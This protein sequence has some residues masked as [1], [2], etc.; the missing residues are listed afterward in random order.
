MLWEQLLNS[1]HRDWRGDGRADDRLDDPAWVRKWM[2]EL[3]L[4]DR[5]LP[6]EEELF[7]LKRLRERIRR[8]AQAFVEGRRPEEGDVEALNR[9]MAGSKV[10]R[11]LAVRDDSRY[12]VELLPLDRRWADVEAEIAASF[13]DLLARGDPSRIRFC[14]NPNC[15]WVYYDETRNRSKRY[16]DDKLCGNLMKVRRF[17]ARQKAEAAESRGTSDEHGGTTS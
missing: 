8:M 13:A 14:D 15:L 12:E 2:D 1:V 16:C 10:V 7:G 3:R 11:R 9:T 17:R 4:G 6:E 5:P